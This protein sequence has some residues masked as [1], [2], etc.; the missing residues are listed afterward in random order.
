M[1]QAFLYIRW[2]SKG[3]QDRGDSRERQQAGGLAL[4][5][6]NGWT[7][8]AEPFGDYGVSA[9]KGD[10]QHTGNLGAF[11]DRVRRGEITPGTVLVCE[12]LDRLSR[13]DMYE[14]QD[15]LREMTRLGLRIATY[16]DGRI[17]DAES[18][19]NANSQQLFVAMQVLMEAHAANLL[20]ETIST[21]V[22]SAWVRNRKRAAESGRVISAHAPGWLRV[23]GKG[24][25]RKFFPI[26]DRV[27][28]VQRIYQW[29]ADGMGA[30]S[31][32]RKLNRDGVKPWGR[33]Y[34]HKRSTTVG[35]E[36]TYVSDIL[37]S[38]AVEGDLEPGAGR[39]RNRQ[40]TGERLV[41]YF[42]KPIV[43]ADLV[44][45]AR[46][47]VA[48]R[49]GKGGNGQEQC[50]NL[51]T[52]SAYCGACGGKMTLVGNSSKPARYLMCINAARGRGCDQKAT[53]AYKPFEKSALDHLL[54]LALDE[55]FFEQADDTHAL[56]VQI[57]EA[58][59]A[60]DL[61]RQSAEAA[62]DFWQRNKSP[63]AE[64][65]VLA[66]E[67]EEGRLR[68]EL[69]GLERSLEAAQGAVSQQE[70]LRRCLLVRDALEHED[71]DTRIAARRKVSTAFREIGAK[72]ECQIING[73]KQMALH[74]VTVDGKPLVIYRFDVAG[75]LLESFDIYEAIHRH[76][77]ANPGLA[78][79]VIE[80][81]NTGPKLLP[82]ELQV[83][84]DAFI[85]R[86]SAA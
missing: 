37:A 56:R 59:K 77:Q 62:Y 17:Y 33:A 13:R 73:Q 85:R 47:A 55:K 1:E 70:H 72:V 50:R 14:T 71:Y 27:E 35:W 52:G 10:N 86:R 82:P 2:S 80:W 45:R 79:R 75:N 36:H 38:T 7:L 15:W 74:G 11:T 67:Q 12:K 57:A 84:V 5:E 30:A 58:K 23:E 49:K 31:I 48:G 54:E 64:R 40:K 24:E 25:D 18:F 21:R 66:L 76:M 83:K 61:N 26:P 81:S 32:A 4:I 8:A 20:S 43:D 46:A 3:K 44:A 68:G 34:H 53:F 28:T 39:R 69:A 9:W 65:R 51:F 6:K 78:E 63:T 16:M 60:I 22:K 29:S 19:S 42:G 41:G